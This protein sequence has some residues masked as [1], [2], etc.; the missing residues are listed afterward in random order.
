MRQLFAFKLTGALAV[1]ALFTACPEPEPPAPITCGAGTEQRNG[2]CIAVI[3]GDITRCGEGTVLDPETNTCQPLIECGAGTTFDPAT[4]RCEPDAVCGEDT[5]FDLPT[6]TCVPEASCSP[7][8]IVNLATRRCESPLQCGPGTILDAASRECRPA[9]ACTPGTIFDEASGLCVGAVVCGAGQV[10]VNGRCVEPNQAIALEADAVESLGQNDPFLGG[11]PELIALEPFGERTIFV[12]GIDRPQDYNGDGVIDQDRD[13]WAFEGAAGDYL[14]VEVLSLGLSGPAFIVEGPNG[15]RRSSTVGFEV[16]PRRELLLPYDGT[17]EITVVPGAFL[18]TGVPNGD[19]TAGYVGV[20]ERRTLPAFTDVTPGADGATPT[21]LT[22]DLLNLDDNFFRIDAPPRSAV[23]V[24]FRNLPADT[25]PSALA[26]TNGL[27]LLSDVQQIA[28]GDWAGI[29]TP[30]N[31]DAILLVD[32]RESIGPAD[33]FTVEVSFVPLIEGGALPSDA[34]SQLGPIDVPGRQTAAFQIVVSEEQV[35]FLD[36]LV[37]FNPDLQIVSAEG[38]RAIILDRDLIPLFLEPGEYVFFVNNDDAG[39][40]NAAGLALTLITPIDIGTFAL[41]GNRSGSM[42]G[43]DLVDTRSGPFEAWGIARVPADSMLELDFDARSGDPDLLLFSANGTPLRGLDRPHARGAL[44]VTSDVDRVLLVLVDSA[45]VNL[46]D[47]SVAARL[48]PLP[49]VLEVEPNDT[50]DRATVLG[51]APV[52]VRGKL[53][54]KEIDVYQFTLD[55]LPAEGQAVRIAFDDLG[56]ENASGGSVTDASS[57]TIYDAQFQPVPSIPFEEITLSGVVF[58]N[59]MLGPNT[60]TILPG[61][62]GAGPFYVEI[63]KLFDTSDSEYTLEIEV[64]DLLVEAEP[65]DDQG[66]ADLLPLPG[67]IVGYRQSASEPDVFHIEVTEDLAPGSAL[68]VEWKHLENNNNIAVALEA[69]GGAV[70]DSQSRVMGSLVVSDLAAGSY[71]LRATAGGTTGSLYGL[72]AFIGDGVE[73]EPNDSVATAHPL[74][75]LSPGSTLQVHGLAVN[76]QDDLF[77]FNLA[78]PLAPGTGLRA[79][80]LNAAD[81][82]NL[83]TELWSGDPANGGVVL[84]GETFDGATVVASPPGTGPFYLRVR[85]AATGAADRYLAKL[86]IG[87]AAEAEP[88]NDAASANLLPA[89]PASI[90]GNIRTGEVDVFRLE[91]DADTTINAAWQNLTDT[92]VLRVSLRDA[93]FIELGA[94][95]SNNGRLNNVSLPAGSYFLV[96]TPISPNATGDRY[97]LSA[98]VV[99]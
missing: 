44:H 70:L 17:Y 88:N 69:P 66:S 37:F 49:P 73:I 92:T 65:N 60:V 20:I 91:L 63:A 97:R 47:W 40:D 4:S 11:A 85:N 64:V 39:A 10:V 80:V 9:P 90:E 8:T 3:P 15:Y 27:R 83:I 38:T 25:L 19:L 33:D 26:F 59:A 89:L 48:S 23:Q 96:V 12:G 93:D 41:D 36:F 84:G 24:T 71:F 52:V 13:V 61:Y 6:R 21:I 77:E 82:S 95:Q 86:F 62:E 72:R 81:T 46:I 54:P 56:V 43:P 53:A 32:W 99:Q 51:A 57:V 31:E 14:T 22:G 2:I 42:T 34:V 58:K 87:G 76:T 68:F 45:G 98:E 55:E 74:G 35:V 79:E 67:E 50:P 18:S 94:A 28:N 1:A 78:A 29:F 30:A 16:E 7:G 75:I 5:L